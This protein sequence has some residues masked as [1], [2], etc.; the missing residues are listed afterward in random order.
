MTNRKSLALHVSLKPSRDIFD[1]VISYAPKPVSTVAEL[2]QHADDDR[3]DADF[4]S[5]MTRAEIVHV[6]ET[7]T[8]CI[9]INSSLTDS[10]FIRSHC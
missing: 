10:E 3:L 5:P 6:K 4:E 9:I 1:L 8:A 2:Y 7:N